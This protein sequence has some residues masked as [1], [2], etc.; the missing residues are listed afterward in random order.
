MFLLKTVL[1]TAGGFVCGSLMFSYYIPKIIRHM[2]IR[3]S[4]SDGN[5]GSSNAVK[6]AG[7]AIGFS[8]MALDVFKA[9]APVY[10][11]VVVF[12]LYGLWLVPVVA[13]PVAGH[14]FSPFLRFKGGKAVSTFYGALLGAVGLTHIVLLPALI[15]AFFTFIVVIRPNSTRVIASIALAFAASLFIEPDLWVKAAL[16]LAGSIVVVK[17]LQSPGREP[18]SLGI[19]HYS[20]TLEEGSLVLHKT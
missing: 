12:H 1:L 6:A 20:L 11:A 10:I 7:P 16:L 3:A 8:C 5:P 18:Y 15:M 2:D 9:F 4:S 13:A 19:W 17:H 14:A